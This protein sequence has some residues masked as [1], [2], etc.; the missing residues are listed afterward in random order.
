MPKI[1][2]KWLSL[3]TSNP[4]LEDNSAKLRVK[5]DGTTIERG[6][7]GLKVK[8]NTYIPTGYIDADTN[9]SANSDVKIATQKAIKTYV[10]GLL[11]ANDAMVFKGTVGTGG[12]LTIAALN[13]LATYGAGWTYRVITAG[14]VRGKV[15]EI[16]DMVIATVDR[17]EASNDADW[18]VVQ[19]NIDGAVVSTETSNSA[20]S[21]PQ[22]N[23]TDGKTLKEAA[24]GLNKI[25]VFNMFPKMIKVTVTAQHITDKYIDVGAK[26]MAVVFPTYG[27]APYVD[28]EEV[29]FFSVFAFPSIGNDKIYIRPFTAG[30]PPMSYPADNDIVEGDVLTILYW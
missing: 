21:I 17:N 7:S 30:D 25:T 2:P 16:G 4:S 29:T 5:V 28:L 23:S 13:A 8:D 9:L 26:H 19:T 12:T 15:C 20:N 18:V 3:D 24:R 10:D 14:T 6:E 22:F 27:G 11:A 1:I